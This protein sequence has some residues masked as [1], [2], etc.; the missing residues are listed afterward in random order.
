[1]YKIYSQTYKSKYKYNGNN[2]HIHT[3]YNVR[4]FIDKIYIPHNQTYIHSVRGA[5][6]VVFF[7]TNK[8]IE[9]W[10]TVFSCQIYVS[11]VPDFMTLSPVKKSYRP[12]F[13]GSALHTIQSPCDLSY[14]SI[15]KHKQYMCSILFSVAKEM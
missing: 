8:K 12:I 13:S 1:M 11:K 4:L 2:I 7:F 6:A 3:R 15:I 9:P 5:R 14:T 10:A